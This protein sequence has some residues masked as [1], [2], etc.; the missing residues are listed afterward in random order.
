M[1][2]LLLTLITY[3]VFVYQ[4]SRPNFTVVVQWIKVHISCKVENLWVASLS[5]ESMEFANLSVNFNKLNI[6]EPCIKHSITMTVS[7]NHVILISFYLKN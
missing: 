5:V 6:E 1:Y 4:T 7:V 3:A 2:S